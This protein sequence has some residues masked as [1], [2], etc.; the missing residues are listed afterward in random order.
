M[1]HK[2]QT[3]RNISIGFARP[4]ADAG[5][6]TDGERK[7]TLKIVLKCD[8][9]GSVE[10]ISA[11][12]AKTGIPG[13]E[14]KVISSGVGAVTKNDLLMALTGSRLV[15][16]FDVDVMP[17]LEQW[18]KEHEV[19]VR[20]YKVVYALSED[21]KGLAR[22]FTEPEPEERIIGKA[23]VIAMF[24][25]SHGNVIAG[26][27]V[28]EGALTVGRDFRIIGAMGPSFTSKIESLQIDRVPIKEAKTR[29]QCGLKLPA[30]SNVKIGDL[31]ESFEAPQARKR[32]PWKPRGIVIRIGEEK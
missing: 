31:V 1:T 19:E 14:I 10:A 30:A 16:G 28:I 2:R 24:K 13:V 21:L 15:V 9:F 12:L 17:K 18:A 11:M 3:R 22:S 7:T 32:L 5:R 8:S 6:Q 27:E 20:I 25:S 29:Q 23:K 26:C 4:A